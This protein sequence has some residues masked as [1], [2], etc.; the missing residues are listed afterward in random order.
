MIRRNELIEDGAGRAMVDVTFTIPAQV[1]DGPVSVVGDFNDWDPYAHPMARQGDGDHVAVIRFPA[2]MTVCFRYLAHDGHWFD[3][4]DINGRDH[5]GGLIHIPHWDDVLDI[6]PELD[7]E[8]DADLEADLEAELEQA[9][10]RRPGKGDRR[11]KT[12]IK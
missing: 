8:L 11:S 2:G 3:D 12:P 5:R 10:L 4:P 1:T 6:D 7:A 9:D